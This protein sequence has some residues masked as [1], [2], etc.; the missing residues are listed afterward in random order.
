MTS[1]S[2]KCHE[3]ATM[4]GT[5]EVQDAMFSYISA[6]QRVPKDH[7]LRP[8]RVILEQ[9]L[10]RLSP[11]LDGMYANTGRPSIPPEKLLRALVLQALYTVRSERMLRSNAVS[12]VCGF[13]NGRR[14][15]RRD[16]VHEESTATTA[17]GHGKEI[18]GSGWFVN[19]ARAKKLLS[20]EH[21]TVD[22]TLRNLTA[23]A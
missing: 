8:I 10:E 12:L 3:E 23:M 19:D 1:A 15:L 9:V 16:G 20:S 2:E 5:E 18:S 17:S 22:G 21:F 6:E 13:A 11:E 7:P 14:D 4:R